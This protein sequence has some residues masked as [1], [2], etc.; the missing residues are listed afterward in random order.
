MALMSDIITVYLKH[1]ELRRKM[2]Y[3]AINLVLMWAENNYVY[4]KYNVLY[5]IC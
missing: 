5:F 4:N 3:I 2:Y 1:N